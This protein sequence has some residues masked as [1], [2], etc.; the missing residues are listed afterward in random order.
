VP[1]HPTQ[2][3]AIEAL[4]DSELASTVD[5]LVTNRASAFTQTPVRAAVLNARFGSLAEVSPTAYHVRLKGADSTDRRNTLC[6][7]LCW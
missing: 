5:K 2:L 7:F 1:L 4:F 6:E 3:A